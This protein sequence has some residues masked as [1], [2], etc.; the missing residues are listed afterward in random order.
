MNSIPAPRVAGSHIQAPERRTAAFD[1]MTATSALTLWVYLAFVVVEFL[2]LGVRSSVIG[3]MRPTVLL[4]GAMGLLLAFQ[5]SLQKYKDT[6]STTRL[7]WVLVAYILVTLP[8]V[9]WPG[10]VLKQNL[11]D[12][13]KVAV[14]F[15]FTIQVIDTLPRLK[16]FVAVVIGCQV[17]RVLEPLYLHLAWGYWGSAAHGFGVYL[18]RLSG[19]PADVVNPNGLGF[20]II[21]ALPFLHFLLFR[22]SSKLY[23]LIYLALLVPLMY[24]LILTGSRSAIV[25]LAV[26]LGMIFLKSE[27]KA[28]FVVTVLAAA[29]FAIPRMSDQQADRYLSLVSDDSTHA[30]TRDG[31]LEGMVDDF[32]T[33]LARPVFGHGLGT[34]QEAKW[35]VIGGTNVPHNMYAEAFIELGAIGLLLFLSLIWSFVRNA[36]DARRAVSQL[37]QDTDFGQDYLVRLADAIQVWVAM[38][39]VFSLAQYG[40]SEF[41]WYLIGGLSVVLFRLARVRAGRRESSA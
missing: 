10:S 33:G 41:H 11:L 8:F 34:G 18:D 25:G 21:T 14:F 32:R 37:S 19:A 35:N 24:A 13:V 23:K 29:A 31:R 7:M 4:V 16:L 12:W 26:V 27:K 40:V 9:E 20:V 15:F 28:L 1:E 30:E 39:L 36:M 22:H 17:F 5:G 2:N 6:S 38:G 3:A